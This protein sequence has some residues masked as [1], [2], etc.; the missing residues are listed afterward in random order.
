MGAIRTVAPGAG[1]KFAGRRWRPPFLHPVHE[2]PRVDE[3]AHFS[4]RVRNCSAS[5][6]SSLAAIL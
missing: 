3:A 2:R 1:L 4:A 6:S 5:N